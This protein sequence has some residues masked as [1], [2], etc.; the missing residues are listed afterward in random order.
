MENFW[1][2]V[3]MDVRLVLMLRHP[4][5]HD[6]AARRGASPRDARAA[7]HLSGAPTA[8]SSM[9]KL[10]ACLLVIAM[11]L[12]CTLVYPLRGLARAAVP[13]G[14]AG[15]RLPRALAARQHVRRIRLVR[16]VDDRQPGPR[17]LP[18]GDAVAAPLAALVERGGERAPAPCPCC[19]RSPSSI[20]SSP[21]RWAS[22]TCATSSTS[23]S[24][25]GASSG[26]RSGCWRRGNGAAG[27]DACAGRWPA[28]CWRSRRCS[29]IFFL[30]QGL[31]D[32]RSLAARS[33][34]RASLHALRARA[35][36]ARRPRSR[37]PGARVPAL[38]G[39]AQSDDRGSAAPGA[40]ASAPACASTSSTSTAA[41][42]SR[43]ST[44]STPTAR[45]WW[46]ARDDGECSRI[47]ARR[48][49][50]PRCCR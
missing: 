4:A 42:R 28:W 2:L 1:Q 16:L 5:A 33:H 30:G 3:F 47:R 38:A 34:P 6:A 48:P 32:A 10:V 37:G 19:T 11:L 26:A 9:A 46:R 17:R 31:L 13:A 18:D 29:A 35:A 12:A 36:G 44:T 24:W 14:A 40:R 23:C 21:S 7:A 27:A 43:G 39:F 8:S 22:S 20:T 49:W 41:R 25:R 45:S 50:W 15:R